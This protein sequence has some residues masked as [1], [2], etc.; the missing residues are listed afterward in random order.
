M[1]ILVVFFGVLI[2]LAIL[3]V[4]FGF[5]TAGSVLVSFVYYGLKTSAVASSLVVGLD[6]FVLLA[7]PCFILSGQMMAK[8]GIAA[9]L[10][11]W[12]G[13]WVGRIRGYLGAV[14]TLASAFFGA[15]SGSSVATVAAIG[16][17]MAPEM[18][19]EG[20]S[21]SYTTAFIAVCGLLGTLIPPSI[22]ALTY[23]LVADVSVLQLWMATIPAGIVMVVGYIGI[24]YIVFGRKQPKA[25]G[26]DAKS[27]GERIKQYFANVGKSTPKAIIALVMPLIIFGGVYGGIFTATEAGSVSVFYAL[28][29]GWV[30]YPLLLKEKPSSLF[31]CM[32][33]SMASAVGIGLLLATAAGAGHLI[34]LSGVA[35]LVA[36]AVTSVIKS[37][38]GFLLA[39]N[40]IT[41]I[42]GMFFECN[43]G[44]ILLTPIFLPTAV[45]FGVTPLHF[46]AI[47]LLNMEIGL[48]TPP[49]AGN[50]FV[51]CGVTGTT[52]DKVV[53]PML[54]Y[55][56]WALFT[57][58]LMTYIPHFHEIFV[59][60]L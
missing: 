45:A 8:S 27:R 51:A 41:L 30:L 3:R 5:A 52:M 34:S 28:F 2:F 60:G 12:I 17:I 44:I 16:G 15:I 49:Q 33:G 31:A 20:Y 47:I 35:N 38:V 26:G 59:P 36:D 24:N 37:R 18:M 39:F 10:V 46:G 11:A 13:A 14:T 42:V 7:I 55:W 1:T 54:P 23:G 29:A 40:I 21:K 19:K 56:I 50:I 4:P 57:L 22:P 43:V 6:S 25:S 53:K 9:S 58:A 48:I 32:R